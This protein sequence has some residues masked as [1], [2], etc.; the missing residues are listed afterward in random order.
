M[1]T[2]LNKVISVVLAIIT[3]LP[4][5]LTGRVGYKKTEVDFDKIIGEMLPVHNIGRMPDHEIDSEVNEYFTEANMTSCRTHDINVT[6]ITGFSPIFQGIR[7]TKRRIISPN[8][9]RLLP[10]FSMPE[11][12][13]FSVS[14]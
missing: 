7:M 8:A 4:N 11:W 5:I 13:R 3:F 1:S 9:T 6:D 2:L 12:S 14:E 10:R